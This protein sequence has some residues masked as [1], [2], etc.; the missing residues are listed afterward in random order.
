MPGNKGKGSH[1]YTVIAVPKKSS[2]RESIL[3]LSLKGL[4]Q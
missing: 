1:D 2:H 3:V 4:P